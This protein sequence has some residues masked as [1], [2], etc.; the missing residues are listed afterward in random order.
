VSERKRILAIDPGKARLGL[1]I[2]DAD[3]RIASPLA[4]WKCRDRD[5]DGRFLQKA[6]ADE[7]VGLVVI[8]LPVHLSGKEGTQARA[9]RAFGAWL[10]ELTGVPCVLYDERFTTREAE[11]H[12]LDAGLTHKQRKARRDRV[13]AQILLQAYLDAGC[14]EETAARALDDAGA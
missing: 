3:R 4:T 9:A 6:I 10:G 1:A 14:P 2:S 11:G 12:L 8:G 7:Q 5:Q 13:A